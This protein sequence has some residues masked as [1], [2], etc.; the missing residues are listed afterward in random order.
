MDR[1]E[2]VG[3]KG[4]EEGEGGISLTLRSAEYATD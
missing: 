2:G 1:K 4:E 3:R